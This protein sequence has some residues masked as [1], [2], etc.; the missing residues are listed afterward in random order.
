MEWW[1]QLILSLVTILFG[2]FLGYSFSRIGAKQERK[3]RTGERLRNAG[4]SLLAE[5]KVNSEIA[6]QPLKKRIVPFVTNAWEA[7][8]G[9]IS[10]LPEELQDTLYQVYVEIQI[11][12]AL[13]EADIHQLD[14]GRG[15][16]NQS[17]KEKTDKVIEI[18]RKAMG[19][20]GSWLGKEKVDETIT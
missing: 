7:N 1:Q 17:Y 14:Y 8:K 4:R 2:A 16:Y 5:L 13:V 3:S 6:A 10:G 15:Y 9:E 18:A 20:L 19:L 11:A 12:N